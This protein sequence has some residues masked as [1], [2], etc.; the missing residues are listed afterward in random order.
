MGDSSELQFIIV[1]LLPVLLFHK[2]EAI[3][4][5]DGMK[6]LDLWSILNLFWVGFTRVKFYS[7]A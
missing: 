4:E 7:F 3:A 6:H 2:Q 5:S 1:T